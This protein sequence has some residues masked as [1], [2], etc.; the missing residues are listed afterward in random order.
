MM[1]EYLVSV[2]NTQKSSL[3]RVDVI[4]NTDGVLQFDLFGPF[5]MKWKK[6]L[7]DCVALLFRGSWEQGM[8]W[9]D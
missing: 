5:N 8:T 9:N 6:G 1:G 3:C 2:M 4:K 7:I